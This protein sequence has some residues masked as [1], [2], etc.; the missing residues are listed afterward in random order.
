MALADELSELRR[1][2]ERNAIRQ[3]ERVLGQRSVTLSGGV[4]RLGR[5]VAAEAEPAVQFLTGYDEGLGTTI[6]YFVLDY[7][8]LDGEDVLA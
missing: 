8:A 7:S 2:L 1:E 6:T 3:V 4:A 5:S